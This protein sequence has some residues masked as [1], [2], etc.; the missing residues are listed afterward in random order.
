MGP[1]DLGS[2]VT[3]TGIWEIVFRLHVLITW[4]M[5]EYKAWF[6]KYILAWYKKRCSSRQDTIEAKP[7]S[8]G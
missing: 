6:E 7:S 1:E 3:L 2:T 5:T 8:S 4:G